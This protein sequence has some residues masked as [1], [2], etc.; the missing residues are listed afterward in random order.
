[1]T[2]IVT[3]IAAVIIFAVLIFFHEFGHFSAAKLVGIKV[4]EF[5]IGMGP[6]VLK[7]RK[8]ETQYSLRALPIGGYVKME[9]EDEKSDDERAFNK[10]PLLARMLVIVAGAFMN[11]VLGFIIFVLMTSMADGIPVP[12]INK[13]ADNMPAQQ[14]GFQVGDRITKLNNEVVHIQEDIQ[15][16]LAK[17]K[18]QEILVTYV[19]NG[20]VAQ[21]KVVPA[22]V[23]IEGY[24]LYRIGY[25]AQNAP[26]NI[27]SITSYSYYK[28]LS[29]IKLITLG[30]GDLVSGR[31]PLNQVAGPV[32]IV[33][34]IG[35]AAQKVGEPGNV[36]LLQLLY[37]SSLITI[38]LGV[39]NLLP[40]PALDGSRV[41][42]LIIEAVRR[43]PVDPEKE[44]MVH[45]IGFAA[46]MVLMIVITFSDVRNIIINLI[47]K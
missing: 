6:L 27:V 16:F 10:K 36:G 31:V 43:K 28:T 11:F 18:E 19:R 4:H 2:S 24:T 41:V 35:G 33:K 30:L 29:F 9:G 46:L 42:F 21:R 3:L 14:A 47:N 37:L 22:K 17:N 32:G 13:L 44:G 45:A 23:E 40:I 5:A 26:K 34:E 8:G 7:F 1:M 25:E 38:N 15:Y 39:V 20:A 12:I